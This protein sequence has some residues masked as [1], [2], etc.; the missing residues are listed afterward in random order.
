M[1]TQ[2]QWLT[3]SPLW[4]QLAPASDKTAFRAPALLRFASDTFMQDL[5]TLLA[6]TQPVWPGWS[7]NRRPGAIRPWGSPELPDRL[8]PPL[9]RGATARNLPTLKLFAPV[10]ARFYLV[11]A[12]LVCRLPALPD[13]T[14]K[15]NMGE[16]TTLYCAR[17]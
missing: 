13:H 6:R 4:P 5:Q 11:T 14:V 12:S 8:A 16:R 15:T 3:P 9:R 10:H 7:R 1:S 2:V 17:Y